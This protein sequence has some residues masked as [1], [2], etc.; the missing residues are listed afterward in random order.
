M[1]PALYYI[2]RYQNTSSKVRHLN[3]SPK[4]WMT[5]FDLIQTARIWWTLKDFKEI[6]RIWKIYQNIRMTPAIMRNGNAILLY[7][8]A[9]KHLACS[10]T[11]QY[12]SHSQN[13]VPGTGKY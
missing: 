10:D 12:Q 6:N 1:G 8:K 11:P 4:T 5:L 3:I 2:W 7:S 13:L 9:L